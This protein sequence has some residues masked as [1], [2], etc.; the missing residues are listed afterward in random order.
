[1][2]RRWPWESLAAPRLP[3]ALGLGGGCRACCRPSQH[4]GSEAD[5]GSRDS[6]GG[7]AGCSSADPISPSRP[8]RQAAPANIQAGPG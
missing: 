7:V 8:K 5:G 2:R 6:K 4:D 1:M 3:A